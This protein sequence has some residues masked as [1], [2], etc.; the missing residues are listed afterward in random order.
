MHY[1]TVTNEVKNDDQAIRICEEI[2]LNKEN[3]RKQDYSEA[4]RQLISTPI[5]Q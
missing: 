3:V 4:I 2:V 1:Q 5:Q